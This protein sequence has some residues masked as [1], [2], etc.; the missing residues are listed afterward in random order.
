ML[1]N[2]VIG[3][4][5]VDTLA[6]IECMHCVHGSRV[7]LS[8]CTTADSSYGRSFSPIGAPEEIWHKTCFFGTL[9]GELAKSYGRNFGQ[10][11][12]LPIFQLNKHLSNCSYSA[13]SLE[14]D[15]A[16]RMFRSINSTS[17]LSLGIWISVPE[18]G[19]REGLENRGGQTSTIYPMEQ[20]QLEVGP[21]PS[22]LAFQALESFVEVPNSAYSDS[23]LQAASLTILESCVAIYGLKI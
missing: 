11:G 18:S 17:A 7:D 13:P 15:R 4:L 23:S 6:V 3:A 5:S 20:W 22:E 9:L 1:G 14:A 8:S 2:V 19:R 10:S 16:P 12:R 21:M